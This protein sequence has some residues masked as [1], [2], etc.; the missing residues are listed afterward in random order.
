MHTPYTHE[1]G[2]EAENNAPGYERARGKG[3]FEHSMPK[4][5]ADQHLSKNNSCTQPGKWSK[6]IED[7]NIV[8]LNEYIPLPY[9]WESN[10]KQEHQAVGVERV[11]GRHPQDG[12]EEEGIHLLPHMRSVRLC[13]SRDAGMMSAGCMCQHGML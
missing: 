4:F 8:T 3:L 11:Q 13:M 1:N 7:V 2:K 6:L 12:F 9:S 5:E 10:S